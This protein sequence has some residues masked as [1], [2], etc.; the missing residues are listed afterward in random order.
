LVD[1]GTVGDDE[2]TAGAEEAPASEAVAPAAQ[3]D[4]EPEQTEPKAVEEP[5]PAPS[6]FT[7]DAALLDEPD[8]W[9]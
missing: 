9:D 7:G 4:S 2:A 8:P 5:K 6:G 1:S 3:A